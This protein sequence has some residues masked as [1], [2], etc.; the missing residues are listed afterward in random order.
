MYYFFIFRYFKAE[1]PVYNGG[2]SEGGEKSSV[3]WRTVWIVS[4]LI[5]NCLVAN[6]QNTNPLEVIEN[7][8]ISLQIL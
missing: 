6:A 8:V 4:E 5:M 3:V 2:I 7:S 1:T